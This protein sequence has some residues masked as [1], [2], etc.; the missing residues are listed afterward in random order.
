MTTS[1]TSAPLLGAVLA[2]RYELVRLIARGGMGDV[3]EAQDRLLRRQVAVKV[4][5]ADALADRSRFDAEV[6]TLAALNHPGLVQVFDAGEHD[7]D[8]YVVL[9]LVDG[10]TLRSVL[11]EHE[12]LSSTEVA[13][14]GE[15]VAAALAYVHGAGVVH[16]DV[17]PSNILCGS[18]GRPRL[19]DFGIARLL[20]TSRIT[21][22]ATTIG[23]AAYMA[24]EQV[25]GRDVTPAADVYALGLVLIEALT[26]RAAFAGVGHEVALARLARD[27]DVETDV[28]TEWHALLAAMTARDPGSRPTA[29]AVST[30]LADL[31]G[32]VAASVL[33]DPTDAPT[34]PVAVIAAAAATGAVG[35]EAAADSAALTQAMA[36]GGGTTVMPAALQPEPEV[37]PLAASA[38]VGAAGTGGAA[39]AWP[40]RRLWVT[41]AIFAVVLLAA[42]MSG[43][44]IGVKAPTPTTQPVVV[45][46][47]TTLPTTTAPPTTSPPRPAKGKGHDKGD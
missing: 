17:T 8:G 41:L 33:T 36:L 44:D 5:R 45:T 7:G 23:T 9:E 27:P 40:R 12:T 22:V 16:R 43:N 2:D 14:L 10:P 39:R 11:A 20:D 21:A 15:A 38:A 32:G 18:D 19:A 24:P 25:E 46:A 3:Y 35:A 28:P 37:A 31:A 34:A 1:S 42:L 30:D 13:A 29:A 6:H 26:G 4:Y 47:P